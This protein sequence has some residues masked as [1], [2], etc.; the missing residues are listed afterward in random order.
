LN[1]HKGAAVYAIYA[2]GLWLWAKVNGEARVAVAEYSYEYRPETIDDV[3][4]IKFLFIAYHILQN[5]IVI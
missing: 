3:I 4:E 2:A 5:L 1:G